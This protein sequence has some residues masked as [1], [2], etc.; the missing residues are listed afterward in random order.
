MLPNGS[1][2]HDDGA[3]HRQDQEEE[4][5][6][7]LLLNTMRILN[8]S[9]HIADCNEGSRSPVQPQLDYYGFNPYYLASVS[10]RALAV[11][12]CLDDICKTARMATAALTPIEVLPLAIS[13]CALQLVV[14]YLEDWAAGCP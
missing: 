12:K 13:Q 4:V 8:M 5:W 11:C 7:Q 3:N 9:T 6:R 14:H 1:Y 10:V 2:H